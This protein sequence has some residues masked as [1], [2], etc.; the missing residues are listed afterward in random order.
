ESLQKVKSKIENMAQAAEV[1]FVAAN[2]HPRGQAAANAVELKSLLSD[3]KVKAPETL[4]NT[5]PVLEEFAVAQSMSDLP[6]SE[7]ENKAKSTSEIQTS[8]TKKKNK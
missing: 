3:E 8:R 6:M 2:N 1:T 7:D 4:V 5:Y